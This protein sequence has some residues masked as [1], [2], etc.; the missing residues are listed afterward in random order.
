MPAFAGMTDPCAS[1]VD[2]RAS[3]QGLG[4]W[5]KANPGQ[6]VSMLLNWPPNSPDLSPIEN[7]WAYMQGKVNRI[8]C[9]IFDEFKQNV[10]HLMQHLPKG[11]TVNLF[12][13]MKSRL[14][15]CIRRGGDKTHY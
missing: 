10:L 7:V 4:E 15:E 9:K 11:M 12:R 2:H 14:Q 8:G 13:S 6:N 5:K 3:A 1:R